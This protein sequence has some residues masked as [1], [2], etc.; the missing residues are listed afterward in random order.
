[1]LEES[2]AVR[3][4][5]QAVAGKFASRHRVGRGAA[6]AWALLTLG[7]GSPAADGVLE[8]WALGREGEV[9]REM[10]GDFERR[11]PET[12]V[13]VQQIPWSAAHEKLLTAYVGGA[14]PDLFQVGNSWIPELAALGAVE[15]LDGWIARSASLS[16][17]DYFPGILDTNVIDGVTYGVPWYVDT[18]LLFYRR[19]ILARAG[20]PEPPRT[21]ATWVEAMGR[22]RAEDGPGRYGIL[23]PL[24]EWQAPV[25]LALQLGA[26]LLRDGDCY[27]AF[28]APAFRQAFEF[29]IDLFRRGLAPAAGEIQSANLYHDFATGFFTFYLSGP[30]SIGEFGRRLPA[31]LQDDWAAAP[32]P[33]PDGVKPAVSLAGGASL[34]INRG[35][36]RKEVAWQLIEYLTEPAQQLHLYRL[37]GDLP[38]RRRAWDD[39]A[40]A[41]NPN[42]GAFWAQLQHVRSTPKIPE[43]ERI[44]TKIGGY[45]EAVVRGDMATPEALKA[46]DGEVDALLEKRRWL[47]RCSARTGD[48]PGRGE[49]E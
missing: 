24:T 4:P 44:A 19:D 35:S 28:S 16:V 30:W 46:L 49:G 48:P 8:L 25:I 26:T 15:P 38:S 1:M 43:W 47:G 5:R 12:R 21:W 13:R 6:A 39:P 18:R 9:V 42:A 41:G 33:S 10:V 27:G 3:H 11:H 31:A 29:Y 7:C 23:L 40:L 45:A 34:A 17:S 36:P 20:Y 32:L 14:L 37:V 22:I 2:A